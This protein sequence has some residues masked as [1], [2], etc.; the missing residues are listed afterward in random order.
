ML[1]KCWDR[2]KTGPIFQSPSPPFNSC[3]ATVEVRKTANE[4][5]K[6]RESL[7]FDVKKSV[8][9]QSQQNAKSSSNSVVISANAIAQV[10]KQIHHIGAE[11]LEA[12]NVRVGVDSRKHFFQN[13]LKLVLIHQ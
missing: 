8:H 1:S 11:R 10:S 5:A 2:V 7:E 4:D 6:R 3:I 12:I 9:A 13:H